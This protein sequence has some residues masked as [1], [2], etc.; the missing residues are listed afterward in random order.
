VSEDTWTVKDLQAQLLGQMGK[1]TGTQNRIMLYRRFFFSKISLKQP[2]AGSH[3][4]LQMNRFQAEKQQQM[5]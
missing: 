2:P 3:F 1:E 4:S 5:P